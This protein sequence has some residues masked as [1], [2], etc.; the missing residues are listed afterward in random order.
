MSL[1]GWDTDGD[2]H[3]LAKTG[4][5]NI[6][7]SHRIILALTLAMVSNVV[8]GSVSEARAGANASGQHLMEVTDAALVDQIRC[9]QAPE[10]ARAIDAMLANRLIRYVDNESGVYLFEPTTPLT[11]LGVRIVHVSGFDGDKAFRGV[12]SSRMAGTAPRPHLEI[13]VAAPVNE[14]RKRAR[15]AGLVER[16]PGQQRGFDASTEGWNSYL[17]HKQGPPTSS[18]RCV[19]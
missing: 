1:P 13:D 2:Q 3:Q 15:D 6:R 4:R 16:L 11:F 5:M 18:I 19:H 12:P 14:L 7:R 17:A 9:R 8:A 10:V